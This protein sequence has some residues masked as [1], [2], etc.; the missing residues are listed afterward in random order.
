M[1]CCL[2]SLCLC[3]PRYEVRLSGHPIP[4]WPFIAKGWDISLLSNGFHSWFSPRL[5]S[6]FIQHQKDTPSTWLRSR[7]PFPTLPL[8]EIRDPWL[9]IKLLAIPLPPFLDGFPSTF[10]VRSGSLAGFP[11]QPEKVNTDLKAVGDITAAA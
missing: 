11:Q 10:C 8:K 1:M 2:P 5:S 4:N 6:S 3:V 9:L 7:L